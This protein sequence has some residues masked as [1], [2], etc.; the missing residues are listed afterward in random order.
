MDLFNPG[1][2]Q[3]AKAKA[4]ARARARDNPHFEPNI[5]TPTLPL[6]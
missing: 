5:Y 3:K 2:E 4:R 1:I 6:L